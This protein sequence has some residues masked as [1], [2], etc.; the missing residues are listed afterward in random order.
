MLFLVFG[1]FSTSNAKAIGLSDGK[2]PFVDSIVYDVIQQDDQA[3]LALQDGDIDLIGETIDDSF[4]QE[5]QESENIEI[6]EKP[7]N[8]YGYITI[9]CAKYPFNITAF[10]RAVAFALDK[11]GIATSIWDGLAIPQDSPVPQINPFSIEGQLPY[12]YYEAHVSTGN[13]LL[14]DEGFVDVD[15]DGYREAPDG[16]NFSVVIEAADSSSAAINT[17]SL[18]ADTLQALHVNATAQPTDFFEYLNRLYFHEDY[19]MAFLGSNYANFDVDWLA[20]EYWSEYADEPYHNFPNFENATYDS[21]RDQLLHATDY[22][23]VYEAASEMQKVLVYQSPILVCYNNY[24]FSAYRTDRFEGFVN[25]AVDGIPSWWTNQ[26]VHLKDSQGGPYG[27]VFTRSNALD[28]D[29]FNILLT[30]ST[31]TLNV[32]DELYDPLIRTD[33]EGKLMPFLSEDYIIETHADNADVPDGH[34]RMT[35]D[36]VTNASWSDG[37]PLTAQDVAFTYNYLRDSDHSY[38]ASYKDSVY[39]AFAPNDHTFVMEFT[40]ES[41]WHLSSIA[42]IPI[43]PKHQWLGVDYQSFFPQYDELITSGPFYVSNYTEDTSIELTRNEYYYLMPYGDVTAQG[44]TVTQTTPPPSTSPEEPVDQLDALVE[45]AHTQWSD[46]SFTPD[47]DP[48]LQEWLD[49]GELDSSIV[50]HD[51]NPSIIVFSAPWSDYDEIRSLLDVQWS[52]NLKALRITKAVAPSQEA[53][54]DL[55]DVSGVT[56]IDTDEYLTPQRDDLSKDSTT[57][58]TDQQVTPDM[59]EFKPIVGASGP[60]ASQFNGS[61]VVV[62]HLDTGC[63]FGQP[64]LQDA[65]HPDTYDP[66]GYS[67]VLTDSLGNTSNIAD[68]NTWLSEG[69]VLTYEVGGKYYLNVTG[70]DPLVNNHGSTRHLMGLLPPYGNGYPA[71]SDI[72]FIG[73]YEDYWGINNV[74]EFVYNEI[75]KDWEIPDPSIAHD[76]FHFGWV[77]QQRQ[78]PYAKMWAPVLVYNS[79]IDN[80]FYVIMDWEGAEGWTALWNGALYYEDID[81][82]T[83]ADRNEVKALFDWNF[84]DD[85]QSEIYDAANPIIANDYTGNGVDDVSYGALCWTMDPGFFTD[86]EIFQGFRSDGDAIAIYFDQG[87][88]GTATAAHIAARGQNTYYDANNESYFQMSGIANAS[89]ILSISFLSSGSDIGAYLWACGFDYDSV[90]GEFN[91]TGNHRVNLTTNSWGWAVEPSEEFGEYSLAWIILSTPGY[92]NASYPGML[93]VF[94]A[95]NEGA[96]YMT[97]GPP[98]CASTVLTVGASTSSQYLEYYYGP[99]QDAMGIASFSSK[100]PAFSGY[101]KPDVLAPG[102]AGYSANPY[103]GQYFQSYWENGPFW[104]SAVSNYT[105]FSGTSQSAPVAAGAVALAIEAL[106]NESI[107]WT[108]DRLKTIMQ[109]TAADMGYDPAVQ[110]FGLIDAEAACKFITENSTFISET[111]DSHN[112]LMD[113]LEGSWEDEVTAVDSRLDTNIPSNPLPRDF[114]DASLYFGNVIAGQTAN[115]TQ[116][117][118]TDPL[119][120]ELTDMTGWSAS[121]YRYQLAEKHTFDSTTFI[122]TDDVSGKTVYGWFDLRDQLGS[123]T[124]DSAVSTYSY[125]T[126]AVSFEDSS[127]SSTGYPWMFLFDWTDDN[128]A[129]GEPNLWNSSTLQGKELTRL[130]AASDSGNQNMMQYATSLSD[131]QTDLDGDLTLVIHDPVFDVDPEY[132]GNS[133]TCTVMFWEEVPAPEL[134]WTSG[135][136]AGTINWTLTAPTD[137]A[138]IHQGFVE[139]S[140]GVDTIR[141]P[142]SYNLVGNL[143]GGAG[144]E[145]ML[146]DH[147]GSELSPYD[148]VSYG[149]MEEGPDDWDFRSFALHN[150]H[151]NANYLGVRL[152]WDDPDSSFSMNIY[153][154]DGLKLADVTDSTDTSASHLL[155]VSTHANETYYLLIHPTLLRSQQELPVNITI[156]A[157]W[158]ESISSPQV[159]PEYYSNSDP[160][161]RTFTDED[162]LTGDHVIVNVTFSEETLPHMPEYTITNTDLEFL[163]GQLFERTGSL[164]IPDVSYDPFS[165]AIDDSQFAWEYISGMKSGETAEVTCDFS[166]SDC[167]IMAWWYS[168]D[169]VVQDNS[170]WTYGNNILGSDLSTGDKPETGQFTA[171]FSGEEATLAIGIF[172]YDGETGSYELAVDTTEGITI[173]SNDP[174]VSYDTY[175]FG[176]NVTRTIRGTAYNGLGQRYD[177]VWTDVDINNFFAPEVEVVSPNG[178]ES[179][180]GANTIVW[181]AQSE[182]ADA[183]FSHEV[184]VSNDG[185]QSYMLIAADLNVTTYSWD[186]SMWETLDSYKV[187][188]LTRDRGMTSFDESDGTF[189][190]GD[191]T[192]EDTAPIVQGY[193]A[194]AF[195]VADPASNVTWRCIDHNPSEI[196]LWLDGSLMWTESWALSVNIS[197]VDCS[198]LPEGIYNYTLQA[199]DQNAHSTSLTTTV[200]IGDVAPAI[201]SPDDLSYVLESTGHEIAWTA[202][203]TIPSHF[204][205]YRNGSVVQSGV[206]DGTDIAVNVDGL[207]PGVHNYTLWLNNTVNHASSDSVLVTVMEDANPPTITSPDDIAYSEGST[208]N[209]ILWSVED[210]SSGNYTVFRNGS[211]VEQGEWTSSPTTL[212]VSIDG[213][214]LGTYNYTVEAIDLH[215]Y[216]ATDTVIVEVIDTIDP[217]ID[218][219]SDVMYMEGETGNS[220]TWNFEDTNLDSYVIMRDSLVVKNGTL[221]SS[222]A[223]IEISVDGLERGIYNYT[224]VVSD[225]AGNTVSDTVYVL[226]D[227]S[228]TTTTETTTTT[229]TPPTTTTTPAGLLDPMVIILVVG[230]ASIAVV[231]IVVLLY[232]RKRRSG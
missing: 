36:I 194:L 34:T 117:I 84:T 81:L 58:E 56:M 65:F 204:I 125:V 185:G 215:E 14:E 218:S 102:S 74:S 133:F 127:V 156:K 68:T 144:E 107:D 199:I 179:W 86:E 113:I 172:D 110:G 30:S 10:R 105:L 32:L 24:E 88:H 221:S 128:P 201:D 16:S 139:V 106:E 63:D 28:V 44:N 124:Y 18:V 170:T 163:Q 46:S 175:N 57:S 181:G 149:C 9:N 1:V 121:P 55:R 224:I 205:V 38:A 67:L 54:T 160:T 48:L 212:N 3:V 29:S 23:D 196:K 146:V 17:S 147:F 217:T 159:Y 136:S 39:A 26:K 43:L 21:W 11:E 95:G 122:D 229:T 203:S 191:V 47:V 145:H 22:D 190:A 132:L 126:V 78:D 141:V 73:L 37:S 66:T 214:S 137:S 94:S 87:T 51:R 231:V 77:Y 135:G 230:I 155:N 31:H 64:D 188:I 208:G 116:S 184:Y 75:W 177:A 89:K 79:T 161:V 176:E 27:G 169:G 100:G 42:D 193:S 108:P 225:V 213:L 83:T 151:A 200:V 40:T 101:S 45:D 183:D 166:N 4:L 134:T 76:E 180:S 90:S 216:R 109:S 8:G 72:G 6:G 207:S 98:G 219:P 148:S 114:A 71:G 210:R 96:G 220:I 143:S 178:G 12:N 167:D 111:L 118:L 222:S 103:Y 2:G 153:D 41:Y 227:S 158:Y 80:Q 69:N 50:T 206:W 171:E 92:L 150:P 182:N 173:H 104:G 157:M 154:A 120:T 70:W 189:T 202:S 130:T 61:G 174:S 15:G 59:E 123:T 35:F 97:T 93:H 142:W 164:V 228:T 85:Y 99:E 25:D 226:V 115:I 13:Q 20:Y 129:D 197:S 62:G 60:T 168:I 131:L 82:N 192:P 186:I 152:L 232:A 138:G 195:D 53:V 119:G 140:D 211:V 5:L 209:S 112:N 198:S 165:G 7:R 91:Y 49:T 52:V 33:S 162:T 223:V 19:D 187:K